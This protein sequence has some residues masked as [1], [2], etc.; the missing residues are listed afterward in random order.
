MSLAYSR[1]SRKRKLAL[2]FI[3]Q[4][5]EARKRRQ[6]AVTAALLLRLVK[7]PVP[8]SRHWYDAILPEYTDPQFCERIRMSRGTF[9]RLAEIFETQMG[10]VEGSM[11]SASGRPRGVTG[12]HAFCAFMYYTSRIVSHS[13]VGDHVGMSK[14]IILSFRVPSEFAFRVRSRSECEWAFYFSIFS[15]CRIFYVHC[16]ADCL[17][18][19]GK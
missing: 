8:I 4:E 18:S 5:E 12:A 9:Y 6:V 3:L 19:C 11:S 1:N 10:V 7:V 17:F 2:A 14:V 16:T 15:T 13:D